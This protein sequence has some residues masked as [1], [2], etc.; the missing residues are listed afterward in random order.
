MSI[1]IDTTDSSTA[2]EIINQV[3]RTNEVEEKLKEF[4]IQKAKVSNHYLVRKGAKKLLDQ[5]NKN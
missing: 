4:V 1:L 3:Y 5:D 2:L